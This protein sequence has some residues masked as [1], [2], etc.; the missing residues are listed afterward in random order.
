MYGF[1]VTQ[2]IGRNYAVPSMS[3]CFNLVA[4]GDCEVGKAVDREDGG[5]AGLMRL[6]VDEAVGVVRAIV[7]GDCCFATIESVDG[8]GEGIDSAV[9]VVR[10]ERA[11]GRQKERRKR[12]GKDVQLLPSVPLNRTQRSV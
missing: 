10:F 3:P 2:A 9:V 1:S 5:S 12:W 7:A 11:C 8:H 6:L 4:V